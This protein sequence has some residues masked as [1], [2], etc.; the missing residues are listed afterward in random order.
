[1][2]YLKFPIVSWK[3]AQD[4][5]TVSTVSG[6]KA[7]A[8]G[9]DQKKCVNQIKSFLN[10]SFAQNPYETFPEFSEPKLE[11]FL[12]P[13]R[14]GYE[15][16]EEFFPAEERLV[17]K[18]PVVWGRRDDDLVVCALP[19]LG[20]TFHCRNEG[21][22][23]K[24]INGQAQSLLNGREPRELSRFLC[25]T[26]I[27]VDT[28]NVRLKIKDKSSAPSNYPVLESV[29]TPF[30]TR[31]HKSSFPQ[32]WQR[33]DLVRSLQL[34][35][36]SP[37]GNLL[38]LGNSG[39]GKSTLLVNAIRKL[40]KAESQF[41]DA[42]LLV[43]T[44]VSQR[45]WFTTA[46]RLIAGMKYLGEWEERVEDVIGELSSIQGILCFENLEQLIRLGGN[47]PAESVA[48]FLIP[49]LQNNE[50]R[51]IIETNAR[52]L[53]ACKRLLPGFDSLF[54]VFEVKDFS[55]EKARQVLLSMAGQFQQ[56]LKLEFD[57]S[58]ADLTYRLFKRYFPYETFPGKCVKFWRELFTEHRLVKD[59]AGSV[60]HREAT[61]CKNRL[62]NR[63]DIGTDQVVSKFITQTGLPEAL[64]RDELV[65]TSEEIF[66]YL[67][68]KIVGQD[69][70]CRTVTNIVTTLKSGLN[71][72]T[73]P[74]GVRLFCG[75]TGVGK[76]E[77]AKTLAGYMFGSAESTSDAK[78][79]DRLIRLDMSEY[80]GFGAAEKLLM[81]SNGEPSKMIQQ[82]RDQPFAVLLLD[83]IEKAAG[84]VFDV[85]MGL[86]DEGRLTDRWG[87]TTDFRSSI[88]IMTSNLGVKKSQPIG[89]ENDESD[90]YEK[91]VRNFFRPEF[92]NRFDGVVSFTSLSQDSIHAITNLEL[93]KVGA[94]SGLQN[95]DL[96]LRWSDEVIDFLVKIGFD[97]RLGARPLQRAIESSVVAPIARI[98]AEEPGRSGLTIQLSMANEQIFVNWS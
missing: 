59:S 45:F 2:N 80:S 29:G 62:N 58:T 15:V 90:S 75:P 46:D 33:D 96:D 60:Q 72:P 41:D 39:V 12:V 61:E 82:I 21:A 17:I 88:V 65:I 94:R 85:L 11:Y 42:D 49:Y 77:M 67:S 4:N 97:K 54:E 52:E 91:E 31:A 1:M 78:H 69:Q 86:F 18:I 50:L 71:D 40:E 93:Q 70:A 6:T 30:G 3:D 79:N 5:F 64:I 43:E 48:A 8:F 27:T 56:N 19:T 35:L 7:T 32:A 76:T 81:Q 20:Q 83:E 84:E 10:W 73:R 95:R 68:S 53:D 16:D 22:I 23:S 34:K 63:F 37:R 36:E 89:F 47:D 55:Q 51:L 14:T 13:I 98:L 9:T 28:L 24:L 74:I 26:E 92:F 87:R 25:P 66:E 44:K 38:I 57:D